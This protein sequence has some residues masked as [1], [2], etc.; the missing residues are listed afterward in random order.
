MNTTSGRPDTSHARFASPL[1][2]YPFLA[3]RTII[4]MSDPKTPRSSDPE[5]RARLDSQLRA[6]LDEVERERREGNTIAQLRSDIRATRD[7]VHDQGVR[8]DEV[9]TELRD[10]RLELH[11]QGRHVS[12]LASEMNLFRMRLDR[13]GRDISAL[14]ARVY[15]TDPDDDTGSHQIQDL[16][17]HLARREAEQKE[18]EAKLEAERKEREKEERESKIWWKRKGW[19]LGFAALAFVFGN[20]IL[21]LIALL[22][23]L[24]RY[25]FAAKH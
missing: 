9:H 24:L 3:S 20:F 4:D 19:D 17:N 12:E 7:E 13:H 11:E 14:K 6:Y 10:T 2:I 16:R 15:H 8:L 18:R 22:W 23:F 1:T 21:G 5:M 25:I